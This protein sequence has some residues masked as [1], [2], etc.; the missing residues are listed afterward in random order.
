MRACLIGKPLGHSYS[1]L[2]HERLGYPYDLVEV[3]AEEIAGVLR[4]GKYEGFNVTI[5]YKKEVIKHLDELDPSAAEIGAVNTVKVRNRRLIGYN[6]DFL[7]LK[8][9]LESEG[10]EVKDK[11]VMILGTGGASATCVA[12]CKSMGAGEITVVGRS[13]PVNYQNCYDKT[14]VQIIFNATPVG[15]HPLSDACPIEV[16]RFPSLTNA[17]DLIYNP[18]QTEFLRRARACGAVGTGG[19]KMLVAQAVF[20]SQIFRDTTVDK[21]FIQQA[22]KEVRL[23]TS[24]IALIGMPGSGKTTVGKLLSEALG[25]QFIDTDEQIERTT[26]KSIPQIFSDDG[27]KVFRDIEQAQVSVA[28]KHPSVI[29]TGG[30]AILREANVRAITRNSVVIWLDRP[31]ESLPLNGRPLSSSLSALN[32]MYSQR[33]PI[34]RDLGDIYIKNDATPEQAVAKILEQLL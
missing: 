28:F 19:L 16:E 33:M 12:V 7:G 26:G 22:M 23:K 6:T 15:M 31:V 14:D 34:Y 17:V 30:G 3:E 5:P 4:S 18:A 20:A 25:K 24:S 13:S 27:E 10:I 1:K 2:I 11:S 9:M 8:Y 32:E 29:A 21:A